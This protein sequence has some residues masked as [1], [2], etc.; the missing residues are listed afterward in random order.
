M[1]KKYLF[2]IISILFVFIMFAGNIYGQGH[3]TVRVGI[4]N[5]GEFQSIDKHGHVWGYNIDYLNAIA[6][7]AHYKIE[8]IDTGNLT[9]GVDMLDRREIDLLAPLQASEKYNGKFEF[10]L[11]P[12][13]YEYGAVYVLNDKFDIDYED[14]KSMSKLKYGAVKE[15]GFS[16]DFINHYC[17]KA[18]FKP[19]IKYYGNTTEMFDALNEGEIDAVVTNVMFYNSK[20]KLLAQFSPSQVFY[21]TYKDNT[22]LIGEINT[23]MEDIKMNNPEFEINLLQKYFPQYSTVVLSYDEKQYL[24]TLPVINV[25]YRASYAPIG[26]T[27]DNGEFAG[28]TREILDYIAE[29]LNIKFNYIPLYGTAI[30]E[31]DIKSK[32]INVVCDVV[33][34]DVNLSINNMSLSLPYIESENAIVTQNNIELFNEDNLKIA[35][36][37]GSK[38]Y[39]KALKKKFPGSMFINYETVKE[40]Y[41]AVLKGEADLLLQNRH[42]VD[43]FLSRPMYEK[44]STIPVSD[45]KDDLCLATIIFNDADF[46]TNTLLDDSR[47]ISAVDKAIRKIDSNK[48]NS[49]ILSETAKVNYSNTAIDILYKYRYPAFIIVI[50]IM[51]L[52]VLISDSNM[53]IAKQRDDLSEKNEMLSKAIVE[54]EKAN[55][56]KSEFLSRMSHEIRTPMNAIIGMAE[57]AMYEQPKAE[58]GD[59][60]SKIN[61]SSQYLLSLINDILDMSRIES[62]KFELNKEWVYP[63]E[64]LNTCIEMIKPL[65]E[66]K[67]INFIYPKVNFNHRYQY[68]VDKMRSIQILMNILNNSYKFTDE[69]GIV[70][71]KIENVE[72]DKANNYAVDRIIISDTGCGMSKE[73]LEKMYEPFAQESGNS[74]KKSVVGSGLGL[75]IVKNILKVMGGSIN[76]KSEKGKGT[77]VTINFPYNYRKKPQ[78]ENRKNE[79][80]LRVLKGKR[81]LIAE[82]N[83]VNTQIVSRLLENKGMVVDCA[84]NGK[85]AVDKIKDMKENTYDLILMDI[86]MPVMDG[87]EATEAIRKMGINIPILALT[88]DVFSGN[89]KNSKLAGVNSYLTKPIE[90][91]K[92][93]SE[94]AN[95]ISYK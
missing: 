27:A 76:V 54:A 58:V 81:V 46:E 24:K 65:M 25:G 1:K 61:S 12:M 14:Y 2:L 48:L 89:E 32:E 66:Q 52:V 72:Q 63:E 20:F 33:Y 85:T 53:K 69:G 51:L 34:N 44:L 41:D 49:I 70:T 84:D 91:N 40:C 90:P 92:L 16:D 29:N 5:L 78:D 21:A 30:E 57:L 39:E 3:K 26:Y 43:M 4:F 55:M 18:D 82:D 79:I 31:D 10:A 45:I 64:I 9:N 71:L 88:A 50:L 36:S 75:S 6:V 62:G 13:C 19:D 56:A 11:Q 67:K 87:I 42:I 74:Y 37:T 80:D 17:V 47:F 94:I 59:Y 23:A 77:V 28:T 8:Y 38:T 68:Y 86:R 93:Y 7:Q 83:L 35:I 73:F 22:K 60:L 15:S 95:L